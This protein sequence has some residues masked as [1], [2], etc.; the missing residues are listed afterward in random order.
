M[1]L[2]PGA[3]LAVSL[4][5]SI[6]VAEMNKRSEVLIPIYLVIPMLKN[7]CEY[8]REEGLA[9]SPISNISMLY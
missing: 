1:G 5:N 2:Q 3:W 7:R 4:P 8:Q 6:D 9:K